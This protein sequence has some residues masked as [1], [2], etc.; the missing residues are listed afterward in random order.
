MTPFLWPQTYSSTSV[1]VRLGRATHWLAVS[2][3]VVLAVGLVGAAIAFGFNG[4]VIEL[5]GFLFGFF[6]LAMI[7]RLVRFILANE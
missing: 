2:V 1:L 3:A 7:G 6:G 4:Q 5:F